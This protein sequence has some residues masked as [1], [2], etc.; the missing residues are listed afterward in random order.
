MVQT[1]ADQFPSVDANF[2]ASRQQQSIVDQFTGRNITVK[3]D[4]FSLIF[5]AS[6]ELD[7]WGRLARATE[8][9]RADL[10]AAEDNRRTIAQSL[11][12]ETVSLYLQIRYLEQQITINRRLVNT[13]EQN[14]ELLDQRYRQGIASVLDVYQAR[15][16]LAQAEAQLPPLLESAGKARHSLAILQG[17]Y[18]ENNDLNISSKW[19]FEVL[20]PVP[21]GLPSELLNRRPD[22]R[23]AE[24]ALQAASA[25]IGVAKAAR[26]PQ[27]SIT[28]SFGYISNELNMLLD[29]TSELWQLTGG[30]LQ[31]V[32]DAGKR[33][34]AQ[35][36]A[37][38]RYEQQLAAYAKTI[39]DALAEVED[40]LL[41]R[42]QQLDLRKRLIRLLS[43][44]QSTLDTA[45]DRYYR[46]LTDY[47]NVLDAQQVLYQA[48]LSLV[49]NENAIYN[50]QV[51]LHRALGGGWERTEG[52]DQ[53]SEGRDQRA[54]DRG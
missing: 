4:T 25:R 33:A 12:A 23:S 24:A 15:R 48:K 38:A 51:Q 14:L 35:E 21:A 47:L 43:E 2:Q 41:T 50:S 26:F 39:L 42:K 16:L 36:A 27:I 9:S 54:E 44:A 29:H 8:A 34:A 3:S 10:M 46:G 28:G 31:P 40:A 22:I 11:V 32:F 45:K 18:P 5:P 37:E 30:C 49:Q 13:Y 19:A 20:P 6:Y 17:K 1:R 7:L 52:R 53:R